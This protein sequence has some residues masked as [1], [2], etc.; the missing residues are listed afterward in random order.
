MK[1]LDLIDDGLLEEDDEVLREAEAEQDG[2]AARARGDDRAVPE[3][4]Q[5]FPDGHVDVVR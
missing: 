1:K 2:D 4:L 3:F 5:V